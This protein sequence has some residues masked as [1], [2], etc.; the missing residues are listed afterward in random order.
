MVERKKR[1]MKNQ[2]QKRLYRIEGAEETTIIES[3]ATHLEL[4]MYYQHYLHNIEQ[5]QFV[6]SETGETK[7]YSFV[8][9]L[10]R[11]VPETSFPNI[12]HFSIKDQ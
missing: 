6:D 1:R 7:K 11:V 8:I 4:K 2:R 5:F 9:F 3:T 10:T 12:Y